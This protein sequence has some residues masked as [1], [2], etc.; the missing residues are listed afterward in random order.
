[1]DH[2]GFDQNSERSLL[3]ALADKV[4]TVFEGPIRSLEVHRDLV[5]CWDSH[6]V[7]LNDRR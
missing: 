3:P 4:I 6:Q 7:D 5:M 2:V 1:M